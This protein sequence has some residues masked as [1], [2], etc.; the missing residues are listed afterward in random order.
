[1]SPHQLCWED[2]TTGGTRWA[3]VE[4][5]N[6]IQSIASVF[7]SLFVGSIIS[8]IITGRVWWQSNTHFRLVPFPIGLNWARCN[9]RNV[10]RPINWHFQVKISHFLSAAAAAA[11]AAGFIFGHRPSVLSI[12]LVTLRLTQLDNIFRLGGGWFNHRLNNGRRS[13]I[14]HSRSIPIFERIVDGS[15]ESDCHRSGQLHVARAPSALMAF[16]LTVQRISWNLLESLGF[17]WILLDSLGF[18]KNLQLVEISQIVEEAA[19]LY[20][21][22]T[23]SW[24]QTSRVWWKLGANASLIQF[25]STFI[26]RDST[27]IPSSS[28]KSTVPQET[29]T[30]RLPN[31]Y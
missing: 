17:S 8:V 21:G 4:T 10:T 15:F 1:M 22:F 12:H 23:K 24:L 2:P 31:V 3:R 26:N 27:Q 25:Q 28:H 6:T 14:N 20:L 7:W 5:R 11:A 18:S 19:G 9:D 13:C 16:Y 30:K 29:S